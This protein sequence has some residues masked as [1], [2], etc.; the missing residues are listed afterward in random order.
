M[1]DAQVT[2][3][4]NNPKNQ[5]SDFLLAERKAKSDFAASAPSLKDERSGLLKALLED[6]LGKI[7][8]G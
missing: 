3:N 2:D 6:L 4:D 1:G 8:R 5:Q 7:F